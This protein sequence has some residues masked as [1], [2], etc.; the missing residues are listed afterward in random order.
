M[1]SLQISFN[2]LSSS[3]RTNEY[4]GVL[5]SDISVCT[6]LSSIPGGSLD[7]FSANT[8]GNDHL[9]LVEHIEVMIYCPNLIAF[10]PLGGFWSQIQYNQQ[11]QAYYQGY[12]DLAFELNKA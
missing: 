8:H 5:L 4:H 12:L 1:A 9:I 3:T 10:Y 2:F 6:F 7:N 11:I